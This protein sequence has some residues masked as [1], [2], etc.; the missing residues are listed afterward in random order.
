[1]M[2][3]TGESVAELF[4]T[5]VATVLKDGHRVSP[6]GMPTREVLDVNLRLTRPRARLLTSSAR[7]LNPAFAVAETVWHLAGSDE[8]WI[9]DYN[10][11][12]RQ[13][14]D[15][16][17]L[18]GAYGPRMR[19]WGGRV[20]QLAA[21]VDQLRADPDSRRALI[22]LYDPARDTAGH[23]DV[24]C[25]LGFRFHIRR[26]RLHMSTTMRGQDA[27]IGLP[28]DLF[29]TTVLH[30]LM[31]GWLNVELGDYH[32]H[33]DSLH[34]YE[35][36]LDRAAAVGTSATSPEMPSLITPWAGFDVLL[37][38]TRAGDPTGHPMWDAVGEMMRSYRLWKCGEHVLAENL[39]TRIR[40]PLGLA[41]LDWY[42]ELRARTSV[43]SG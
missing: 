29:F 30:E 3:Y 14:A 43:A 22:Q 8:P 15:E 21:V 13:F 34:L 11:R 41:L 1:M 4:T 40:S 23:R 28:Y 10:G 18:R 31:A 39:A 24:P 2:S 12:L 33:I 42:E 16:G 26:H 27:W 20:D 5:V 36:D 35:H 19:R 38:R 32:H 25:T 37:A 6:R 17:V 7:V 9:F